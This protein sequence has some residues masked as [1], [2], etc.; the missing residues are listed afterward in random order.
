MPIAKTSFTNP[1]VVE[2]RAEVRFPNDLR[3]ADDR[4]GFHGTI[5]KE[6]PIVI[7][8]DQKQLQYD[9]GDYT[10]YTENQAY[11]LEIGMNY[12]RLVAMKYM[13]FQDFKKMYLATLS[14]F[15]HHYR[16]AGLNTFALQYM[17]KLAL[18]GET[19]FDECFA[20][21]VEFPEELGAQIYAG[22]GSLIVKEDD[23]FIVLEFKPQLFGAPGQPYGLNLLFATQR[24]LVASGD[25]NDVTAVLD[26]A[27]T[28]LTD[29]FFSVLRPRLIEHLKS[30]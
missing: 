22:I 11:R 4:A 15:T 3:V 1:P 17:N 18:P 7:M 23:Q 2:V 26:R 9:F 8:P 5:K 24:Q 13:G 10:V 28:R 12:F 27:H 30:L 25:Q 21:K 16:I 14:M 6:F 19:T 29:F 20:V